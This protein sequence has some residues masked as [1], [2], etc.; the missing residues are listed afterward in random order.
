[1]SLSDSLT[2]SLSLSLSVSVSVSYQLLVNEL[3]YGIVKLSNCLV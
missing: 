2:D 1:M 3:C